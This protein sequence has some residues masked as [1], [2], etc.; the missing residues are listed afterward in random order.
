MIHKDYTINITS[1]K[2]SGVET[3]APSR[4]MI[5]EALKEEEKHKFIFTRNVFD[6]MEEGEIPDKEARLE[7]DAVGLVKRQI[8]NEPIL[9]E[10]V[11][12]FE[13]HPGNFLQRTP[14]DWALSL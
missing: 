9:N 5:A 12:Y 11:Y 8:D 14:P 10:D 6:A 3:V 13:W 4:L 7:K 2:N 1:W